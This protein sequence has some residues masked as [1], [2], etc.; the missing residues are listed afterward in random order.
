MNNLVYTND[1]IVALIPRIVKHV[2]KNGRI[3]YP[4]DILGM[5]YEASSDFDPK[6]PTADELKNSGEY[7][8]IASVAHFNAE[9]PKDDDIAYQLRQK[10]EAELK[11]PKKKSVQQAPTKKAEADM[12]QAS[13]VEDIAQHIED[14]KSF[15][16]VCTRCGKTYY[17][18]AKN[19]RL[20]PDCKKESKKVT[21]REYMKR[22]RE[23]ISKAACSDKSAD[24]YADRYADSV[25][26]EVDSIESY[27]RDIL[28][29]GDD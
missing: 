20:C 5:I 8:Q 10:E 22:H 29:L 12:Q 26:N 3:F 25:A 24:R 17:T 28:A 13:D 9:P 19:Q 4:E 16:K 18:T 27:A 21:N 15:K 14:A 2:D 7:E 1:L 11:A 6:V 23:K